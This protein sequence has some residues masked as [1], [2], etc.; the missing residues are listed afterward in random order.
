MLKLHCSDKIQLKIGE[1]L[2]KNLNGYIKEILPKNI[3]NAH[4]ILF[5]TLIKFDVNN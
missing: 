1:K 3:Y 5:I 4:G 2:L